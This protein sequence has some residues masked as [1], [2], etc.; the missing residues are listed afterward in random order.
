[1]GS[2]VWWVHP[3]PTPAMGLVAIRNDGVSLGT[4][5]ISSITWISF[6]LVAPVVVTSQ[7]DLSSK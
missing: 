4:V 6:F 5:D 7:K 3:V 2:R 1:M